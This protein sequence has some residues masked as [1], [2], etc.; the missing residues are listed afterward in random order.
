LNLF[1]IMPFVFFSKRISF[2]PVNLPGQNKAKFLSNGQRGFRRLYARSNI[3]CRD[4]NLTASPI[5][6]VDFL[7]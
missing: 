3:V 5:N 2:C 7:R 1:H 4:K 6:P